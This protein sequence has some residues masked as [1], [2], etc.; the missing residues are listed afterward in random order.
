MQVEATLAAAAGRVEAGFALPGWRPSGGLPPG[1]AVSGELR[2]RLEDLTWLPLLTAQLDDTAGHI[3]TDLSLTGTLD[4]PLVGGDLR[5]VDGRALIPAAGI[6]VEALTLVG[7]GERSERLAL[8]GS[9][10]SGDGS[11]RFDGRLEA[12]RLT[13]WR[14]RLAV[15]GE[16]FEA[17]RRPE[18][19]LAISPDLS[20]DVVPGEVELG[21]RLDV[22]IATIELPE[23]S[24]AVQPSDDVVVVGTGPAN[25]ET[26]VVR[27]DVT[28]G[29]GD[30]VR[31]RGY[32]FE[33]NITGNL[34]VLEQPGR[35]ALG[36]GELRIID[37]RY[38]AWGQDLAIEE[39]RLLFANT[40]LD[41]PG[42]DIRATRRRLVDVTAGI[43]VSGRLSEPEI[44]LFSE[45]PMDDTDILSYIV[46]GRPMSEASGDDGDV[47][48]KAAT[49]LQLAGGEVLARRIGQRFGIEEVSVEQGTTP[50]SAALV[51]G[52]YLSPSL[53]VRYSIGLT[54]S[55]NVLRATY[56][57]SRRWSV[58]TETG[59]HSGA[60]IIFSIER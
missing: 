29:L 56:T 10:R 13:S 42:L 8:Q 5:L 36:R 46:L 26:W 17:V 25:A 20:V 48:M 41:D 24:S 47:L 33:G 52:T 3:D 40:P 30:R 15:A 50:E 1:Q 11:L 43:Q 60:D 4:E 53:Y 6:T 2:A 51:L 21:G 57:I 7:H 35:P 55:V 27:S 38:R 54:E 14:A 39:G 31:L 9:A 22:P 37:G 19:R 32:G 45:P 18:A 16:D 34:R 58:E 59:P 28:V 49:A 12:D 23:R 44:T